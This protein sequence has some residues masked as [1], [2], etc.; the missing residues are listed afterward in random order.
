MHCE[1]LKCWNK[2]DKHKVVA[3]FGRDASRE[4]Q[5]QSGKLQCKY[6][7][8]RSTVKHECSI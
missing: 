5:I 3:Y 8:S 7:R 2:V 1:V 4:D 6:T